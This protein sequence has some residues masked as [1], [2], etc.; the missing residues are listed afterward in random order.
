ARARARIDFYSEA[1]A[2]TSD[3]SRKVAFLEKLAQIWEDEV[4]SPEKALEV[5]REVLSVEP[6]RRSAVL[7]LERNPARAGH[8][9]ELFRALVLEADQSKNPALERSLLLRAAEIASGDLGD[10][11]TAL[12]LV[13]RVLA[14]NAGDPLAL[15]AACRVHQRTGRHD[16]ALAQLRVLL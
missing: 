2:K 8:A 11:D 5:Y 14:K 15:R 16:E 9:R 4:R 12:D 3:P 1:A 7:A 6:E 10:A 13:R